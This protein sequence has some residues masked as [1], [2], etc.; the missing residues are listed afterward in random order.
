MFDLLTRKEHEVLDLLCEGLDPHEVAER[1]S[2]SMETVRTHIKRIR[3]K[4]GE[5]T[6][7]KVIIKELMARYGVAA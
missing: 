1:L 3:E 7:L 6:I 5:P 2:I 4:R